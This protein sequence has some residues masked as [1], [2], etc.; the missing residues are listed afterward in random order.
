MTRRRLLQFA[1]VLLSTACDIGPWSLAGTYAGERG[2]RAVLTLSSDG[3][4][5]LDAGIRSME[6]TWERR[7]DQVLLMTPVG[8]GKV[9]TIERTLAGTTLVGNGRNERLRK[10]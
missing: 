1:A 8:V 10:R 9:Y 7:G 4:W 2:G 6:G 3:R 5:V